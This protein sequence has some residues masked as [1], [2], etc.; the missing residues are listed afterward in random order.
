MKT[1]DYDKAYEFGGE[2]QVVFTRIERSPVVTIAAIN[3]FALGGGLELAIASGYSCSFK[4]R[5]IGSPVGSGLI[6]DFG[7]TQRLPV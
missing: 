1:Y 6:P 3:G 7:G 4:E 5:K 2:G